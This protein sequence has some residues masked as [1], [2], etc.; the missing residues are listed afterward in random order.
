MWIETVKISEKDKWT[1][2]FKNL[3]KLKDGKEIVYTVGEKAVSGYE[4][5][6]IGYNIINTYEEKE[7][8]RKEYKIPNT[9]I[10]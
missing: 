8:P 3:P 10:E 1:Y 9:G 6:V 2:T 5:K 7:K 4:K